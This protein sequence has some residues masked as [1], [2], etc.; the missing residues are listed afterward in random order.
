MQSSKV[1]R[2]IVI[3]PIVMSLIALAMAI[4]AHFQYG[5]NLPADEGWQAHL[6]QLLIALQ[7]PSQIVLILSRRRSPRQLFPV[8]ALQVALIALAL[9]TVRHFGM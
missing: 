5:S 9:G 6:F 7:I 2:I 3:A 4:E 8:L 1:Q